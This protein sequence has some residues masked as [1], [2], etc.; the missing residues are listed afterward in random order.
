MQILWF[1]Y[2]KR[3]IQAFD[4]QNQWG[5]TFDK[6]FIGMEVFTLDRLSNFLIPHPS[7]KCWTLPKVCYFK[8][9]CKKWPL[10]LVYILVDLFGATPFA[11]APAPAPVPAPSGGQPANINNP[12]STQPITGGASDPFGMPAFNPSSSQQSAS[13]LD[14][15][16]QQVDREL[17]D[18]Q[19]GNTYYINTFLHLFFIS[20]HACCVS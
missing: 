15:Q 3:G 6:M 1:Y 14:Q 5:L 4:K 20:Q 8:Y 7:Q 11:P 16:I 19:V 13:A 12:F 10:I 17:M 18:L 9:I 2:E